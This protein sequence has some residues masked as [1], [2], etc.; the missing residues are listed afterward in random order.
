MALPLYNDCKPI[1]GR[2]WHAGLWFDKFFDKYDQHWKVPKDGTGK[3]AWIKTVANKEKVGDET[4]EIYANRQKSLVATLD[5]QS[6]TV[7][8]D[9]H[10]VTGLGNNH[11][12]ENGFAW[13]PTLGVPYLAGA[14]VKGLLRAWCEVCMGWKISEK[15]KK[16]DPC[17][18]Q[19]FGDETQAGELIFFDALPTAPVKLKADV[20]TPHYG[21]WYEEGDKS[22][23]KDGRNIPADWH[24]P[25][26]LPF[27][28][29][30]PGQSFQ[31]S[32]ATRPHSNIDLGDVVKELKLAL[33][34]L[35]AGA[36]TAVGYGRMKEAPLVPKNRLFKVGNQATVKR[37]EDPKGKGRYWF[38][39]ENGFGGVVI[40]HE[41]SPK[42]ELGETT[43]LW[44]KSPTDRGY[45]FSVRVPINRK[46][47]VGKQK[48]SGFNYR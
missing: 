10:F 37:V 41:E 46:Q 14:A 20:M 1:R 17:L 39:D 26:P 19:W 31:F 9:W 34:C 27:L 47:T 45:N 33:A 24:N 32:V 3:L 6:L 29:V 8:T 2:N 21:Q 25:I 15:D 5:G 30:A 36:K 18:L 28:V 40:P 48:K 44:V 12:V 16:D 11:P 4:V 13:H 38:Q 7:K 35:G 42:I 43:Q 23:K 22:P